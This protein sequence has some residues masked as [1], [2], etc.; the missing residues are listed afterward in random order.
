MRQEK[1]VKIYKSD[2]DSR[3][4]EE[5]WKKLKEINGN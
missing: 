5:R 4:K 2:K 1:N 3:F